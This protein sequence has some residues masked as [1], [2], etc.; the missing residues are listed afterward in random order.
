M[1]RILFFGLIVTILSS[2][3]NSGNGQL[4]GTQ[5]RAIWQPTDPYGMVFIPQ[6]SFVMGPSDQD[7]PFANVTSAKKVS[8]GAFYMDETEITN[9]EYRQ[10]TNWVRDSIAHTILSMLDEEHLITE[11]KY[12]NPIETSWGTSGLI[13]WN[14]DIRWDDIEVREELDQEEMYLPEHERFNG[15]REIDTR[16]LIYV[17]QELDLKKA[18][19]KANREGDAPGKRDRPHFLKV[20]KV[21]IFQTLLLGCTII[22]IPLMSQ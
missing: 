4:I 6:G 10:F 18:V 16:K 1:K 22:L 2:C 21:N 13:N 12:K 15:K 20:V 11:D 8:V 7:V 17:Y 9:N 19:R 5:N 3:G 14:K